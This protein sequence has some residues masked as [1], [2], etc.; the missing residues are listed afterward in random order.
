MY[1]VQ[2]GV[3]AVDM[4]SL[5]YNGVLKSA[6]CKSAFDKVNA[7]TLLSSGHGFLKKQGHFICAAHFR[8]L[9][10]HWKLM[11]EDSIAIKKFGK[12]QPIRVK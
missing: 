4:T 12:R 8:K 11:N 5:M 6:F 10:W 3:S 9:K 2:L 1:L 7:Q